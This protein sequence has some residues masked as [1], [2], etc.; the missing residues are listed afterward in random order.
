MR[1]RT[2]LFSLLLPVAALADS[3]GMQPGQY[4]YNV[5][6]EMPGMPFAMPAQKF[7]HCLTQADVDGGDQFK[8]QQNK[9]CV[10]K[11]LKQSAGKASFDVACKDGTT[12]SAEYAFDATSMTGKTVMDHGGQAMTMNMSAKRVGGCP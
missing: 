4:D 10:V 6:M 2:T 3:T 7:K 12:G 8:D 11:N 5:K 9:D 1:I